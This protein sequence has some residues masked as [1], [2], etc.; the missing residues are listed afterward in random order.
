[1]AEDSRMTAAQVVDKLMAFEHADVLRESVAFMVAELME[2]EVAAQ[3][4]A[5]L[6]ERAPSVR[7]RSATGTASAAWDTRVGAIE[8]RSRSC[9]GQLFPELSGAAPA[10]RAGAGRGRPG[11]LCQRRLHAQG[12][13]AGRADGPAMSKDQVSRLCR[14]LDEQVRRSASGRWRARY[15]Y[16]WLDAK[17]ERVRERGACVRRPGDRLRRPRDRPPR[18]D[19]P[20]R[21]RDRDRGVLARF[22]RSLR[23]RGLNGVRLCVSDSHEGL[24]RHRQV[25][26]CPWQRCTVSAGPP[27][28]RY[29]RRPGVSTD[30]HH[31]LA[32][33]EEEEADGPADSHPLCSSIALV[34]PFVERARCHPEG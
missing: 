33:D 8:L 27:E 24:A 31:T 6:G 17:L 23:A 19:R 9:V 26:G 12:R 13:P 7:R 3:I 32:P 18:G 29:G 14:G 16:L 21:R 25:L 11:G 5:E 2:A 10:R 15:P 28:R 4:G 20:R 1:M 22:L 30:A 34:R